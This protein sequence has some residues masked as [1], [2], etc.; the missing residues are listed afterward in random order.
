MALVNVV[1]MVR[2][3]FFPMLTLMFGLLWNNT[4]TRITVN[5]IRSHAP[6]R[7]R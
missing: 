1:N 3:A 5:T 6:G 4:H 7:S 2:D